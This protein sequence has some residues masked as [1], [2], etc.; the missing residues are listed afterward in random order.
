MAAL[1][2]ALVLRRPPPGLVQHSDR[3]RQYCSGAY[4]KMLRDADVAISMVETAFKTTK[5]EMLWRTTFLTRP[6]AELALGRYID[7]FYSRCDSTQHLVIRALVPSRPSHGSTTARPSSQ[8]SLL[9]EQSD[10]WATQRARYVTLETIGFVSD[11]PTVSLPA[12]AG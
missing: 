12:V 6:Q 3:G 4:Q 5:A 1:Q 11:N 7:R 10:E 9:L 8:G 2:R